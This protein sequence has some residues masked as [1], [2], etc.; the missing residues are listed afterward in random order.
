MSTSSLV[1]LAG[2][3]ATRKLEHLEATAAGL[4]LARVPP[5]EGAEREGDCA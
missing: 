4:R 1:A 3:A 5:Y 2:I